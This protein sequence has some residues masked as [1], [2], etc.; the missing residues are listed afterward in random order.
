MIIKPD[1]LFWWLT[2]NAAILKTR[3]LAK[4]EQTEKKNESFFGKTPKK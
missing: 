4:N 1:L 3:F 2:K